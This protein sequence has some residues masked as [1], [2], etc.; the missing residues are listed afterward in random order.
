MERHCAV[1]LYTLVQPAREWEYVSRGQSNAKRREAQ[2]SSEVLVWTAGW[3]AAS[4]GRC[5]VAAGDR[6]VIISESGGDGGWPEMT[7]VGCT[8]YKAAHCPGE[9]DAEL[10][11]GTTRTLLG[12]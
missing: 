8:V 2:A 3:P 11:E 12:V 10:R 4:Y 9:K 6:T 5:M 7:L 1:L